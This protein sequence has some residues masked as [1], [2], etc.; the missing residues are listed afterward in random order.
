[1]SAEELCASIEVYQTQLKEIEEILSN[2]SDEEKQQLQELQENLLSLL[3]L[4]LRQLNQHSDRGNEVDNDVGNNVQ[5]QTSD[6]CNSG[7]SQI[8]TF[9]DEFALFQSEIAEITGD[10]VEN[11]REEEVP[12]YSKEYLNGLEGTKCQSPF[13]E[14]WGGHSYHNAVILSIEMQEDGEIDL[15]NPKVRVLYS[16]P[17]SLD[18]LTCRYFLSGRCK[19]SDESCRFSHGKI[20]PVYDIKEYREPVYESIISGTRVLVQHS[21]DLWTAATVQDVLEDRSAFCVMFDNNKKVAEVLP[22]QIIPVQ[23]DDDEENGNDLSPCDKTDLQESPSEGSFQE[24]SD[25]DSSDVEAAVFVPTNSWLQHSLSQRLGDWEKFT[26]GIGSKLMQKM[27]YV[28]GTGLGPSGEG[29]VEPVVAYV[30]PQ[31][32]SLDRCMELREAS[33]G[34]EML[35]VEKRLEREKRREEAKS[36]QAAERMRNRTSVFDIINKKLGG[37]GKYESD[38][39]DDG[40][41][42]P[43]MNVS[44]TALQKDTARDLNLKNYHLSKNI[45]QI[46]REILKMEE[47]KDRQRNNDAAIKILDSKLQMKR[48]DLQRMQEAERKVQ[49]EQKHR[50][51][52]KKYCVF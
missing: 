3:E 36:A 32:V 39:D 4:T 6:E 18:M 20:V 49:G 42:R 2:A 19:F 1:M 10:T 33:N 16:Q 48:L 26:T 22:E 41:Q 21:E 25:E 11:N 37:K 45:R 24:A 51:D 14:R 5:E 30:Y 35:Q 31:G 38:D 8:K 15:N 40:N 44:N 17:T 29:R 34:E 46:Q 50:K 9:D 13:T 47:S 52:K 23:G 12:K 43:A 27:G 7:N 28:V